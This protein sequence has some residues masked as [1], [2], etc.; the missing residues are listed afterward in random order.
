[1]ATRSL[2]KI[3]YPRLEF[4][5][6]VRCGKPAQKAQCFGLCMSRRTT[7]CGPCGA[8]EAAWMYKASCEPFPASLA[9]LKQSDSLVFVRP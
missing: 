1:M 8:A 7:R 4:L 5:M 9:P 6:R 3:V 2:Y